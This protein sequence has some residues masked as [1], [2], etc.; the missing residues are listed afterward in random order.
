MM[1]DRPDVAVALAYRLEQRARE[2][3][4]FFRPD[5]EIDHLWKFTEPGGI[6]VVLGSLIAER[7]RLREQMLAATGED[8][9]WFGEA[10]RLKKLLDNILSAP[11]ASDETV[12]VEFARNAIRA[13]IIKGGTDGR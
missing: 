4:A 7:D 6:S 3:I 10:K 13:R 5:N 9:R 8:L 11:S 2:T 1:H 12:Q